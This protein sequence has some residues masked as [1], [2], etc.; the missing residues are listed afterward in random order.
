MKDIFVYDDED[1]NVWVEV[2]C[3]DKLTKVH[4]DFFSKYERINFED[5]FIFDQPFDNLPDS[6]THLKFGRYFNQPV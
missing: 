1:G 3:K 4:L 5:Y 6:I 2:F